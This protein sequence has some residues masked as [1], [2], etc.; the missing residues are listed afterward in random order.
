MYYLEHCLREAGVASVASISLLRT[1][2][3]DW[4]YR[5]LRADL[6]DL[7]PGASVTVAAPD[8]I[9][10]AADLVVAPFTDEPAFPHQ[11][12]V[13]RHLREL[14]ALSR[15]LPRDAWVVLFRAAWRDAEVVR[16]GR[17]RSTCRRKRLERLAV[18][19]L[20]GAPIVRRLLRPLY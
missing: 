3:Q 17:L 10:A 7:F 1:A 13:G 6:L 18:S 5:D 16:P 15:R 19:L 4:V 20:S 11:D 9:P 8:H 14:E 2:D 12:V